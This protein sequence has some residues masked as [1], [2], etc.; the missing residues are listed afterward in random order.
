MEQLVI[1]AALYDVHGKGVKE[2]RER[3]EIGIA[4]SKY[5]RLTKIQ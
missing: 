4:K 1:D 2:R 3:R 5:G